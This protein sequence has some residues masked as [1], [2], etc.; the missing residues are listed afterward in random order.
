MHWIEKR[1][2]GGA[3]AFSLYLPPISSL[4]EIQSDGFPGAQWSVNT[5]QSLI[6]CVKLAQGGIHTIF[7]REVCS[8]WKVNYGP[9]PFPIKAKKYAK[10]SIWHFEID[11]NLFTRRGTRKMHGKLTAL[12]SWG[13]FIRSHN[14]IGMQNGGRF[15]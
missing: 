13:S 2:D 6:G 15:S 12:G 7:R 5:Q 8:A 9:L 4:V 10:D 1:M 11:P 3:D 14:R